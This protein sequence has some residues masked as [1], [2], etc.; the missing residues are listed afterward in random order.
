MND[1]SEREVA[2]FGKITAGIT[3]EMKNVLAIIKESSGLMEDIISLAPEALGRYQEKFKTSLNRIKDQIRRGVSL[4][5]R[6]NTFAH[7]SDDAV[8]AVDLDEIIELIAALSHRFARLQHVDLRADL[9]EPSGRRLHVKTHPVRMQMALFAAIECCLEAVPA[10]GVVRLGR[11]RL[12]GGNAVNIRCEGELS[13]SSEFI[14]TLR[15]ADK[16]TA[17]QAVAASIRVS[18]EFDE[19]APGIV[20]FLT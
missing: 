20:L 3:H 12:N 2:F 14:D 13:D 6:L 7:T 11:S 15:A 1:W 19:S 9:S 4:T 8:A 18:A 17:L 5:D 16:W 10:G